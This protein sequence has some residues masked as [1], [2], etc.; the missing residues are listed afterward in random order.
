MGLFDEVMKLLAFAA[1]A[2][3]E[4][5][6][7][8]EIST[9]RQESSAEGETTDCHPPFPTIPDYEILR[10]L[11][12]GGMGVVYQARQR[13][14]NRVVALKMLHAGLNAGADQQIRFRNEA[15][16]AAQLE[17]PHI[18]PVYEVGEQGAATFL[19][20]KYVAGTNL[21]E[22]VRQRPLP[23]KQA[24]VLTR[25]LAQAVQ[26]AHERGILHRD[27]KP[28]NVLL[29]DTGEPHLTDF[30][31][32]K[33]LEGGP[34]LT[35]S[36]VIAGTPVYLSPEQAAGQAKKVTIQSDVYG[37]GAILYECLTTAPPCTGDSLGEIL[38]R[39]REIE[40][41]APRRLNPSVPRDLEAIC[42]RCLEKDP[43]KRYATATELADDLSRFLNGEPTQARPV[44]TIVR[45]GRWCRR[46][47]AVAALAASL[48]IVLGTASPALTWSLLKT[49]QAL[50]AEEQARKEVEQ[51]LL[52]EKVARER[53]EKMVAL[54]EKTFLVEESEALLP[55]FDGLADHVFG[56]MLDPEKLLQARLER[57]LAEATRSVDQDANI[58]EPAKAR[59]RFAF[60]A[61]YLRIGLRE[62]AVRCLEQTLQARQA[63]FGADHPDNTKV[64]V[65]L[66]QAYDQSKPEQKARA[67]ALWDRALA[68]RRTK[69]G[70]KHQETLIMEIMERADSPAAVAIPRLEELRRQTQ[71]V[72]DEDH[73][74]RLVT[75]FF[76]AFYLLESRRDRE[77]EGLI[78]GTLP[79]CEASLGRT[80]P[81]TQHLLVMRAETARRITLG[82]TAALPSLE[83]NLN[84][85]RERYGS[86]HPKTQLSMRQLAIGYHTGNR[87]AEAERL[88]RERLGQMREKHLAKALEIA[89][90]MKDLGLCLLHD[91]KLAE[92]ESLFRSTALLRR[93]LIPA[94]DWQTYD[95]LHL[96]GVALF[97]QDRHDEA[98][99]Y[100]LEA[101]QG[102]DGAVKS[103]QEAKGIHDALSWTET[104]L[105][106]LYK[107]WG[108]PELAKEWMSKGRAKNAPP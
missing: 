33:R 39:V 68:I 21:G 106:N 45:A 4:G 54:L 57:M 38:Q 20:M 75:D 3:A 8:P 64:M 89:E 55:G 95:V 78:E 87:F 81:L 80:H 10:V 1:Q 23:M 32:A 13:S 44:G 76:L 49:S 47:P 29:D 88:Y 17:H 71:E 26:H 5:F 22:V 65:L 53:A 100:L 15:E 62:H 104:Q 52:A 97:S 73:P 12:Q 25:T 16:A 36:G 72:L 59:L 14:L 7:E 91:R 92:A 40:P 69:L 19:V 51:A 105:V 30:G 9:P 83:E 37:L 24:A 41:V 102:L 31:L 101:Q 46:R 82:V 85:H 108:K 43:R 56:P 84:R 61:A 99:K 107:K 103:A 11:G 63:E 67:D 86:D 34:N 74:I 70:P 42:L 96:L 66:T 48:L 60:G 18:V 77:A 94:T 50:Q 58:D 2:E 35:H 93:S 79:H 6:L 27:L 90:S 28:A 98:E